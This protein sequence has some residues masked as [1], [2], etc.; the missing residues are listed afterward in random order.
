MVLAVAGPALAQNLGNTREPYFKDTPI[1]LYTAPEECR[2]GGDTFAEAFVIE[3]LPFTDTGTTV[4]YVNDYDE[5]CPYQGSTSPDVVYRFTPDQ[6]MVIDVDLCGS[7]YDTKTYIYDETFFR[8][9]CN[10]DFYFNEVCGM[11]VSKIEYAQLLYGHSYYFVVDGYGGDA[12][13]Y[14][15]NIT[16][17][18]NCVIECPTD[19]VDEGEPALH[20]GYVDMHNGGCNSWDYGSPFQEIN[21]T[22]DEDGD[23]PYDG[24]AWLCGTSGWYLVSNNSFRDTDWFRVYALHDGV[25]DFTVLTEYPCF[26]FKLAPTDCEGVAVELQAISDCWVPQT[27]SFPVT[28]GEEIWLWVGPTEFDGPVTEFLYFMTVTNNQFDV[29][30]DEDMSWGGVKALYR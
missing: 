12:G 14:L 28:A 6:D 26:M 23:P 13:E 4:G 11:Y 7:V 8:I 30:P 16:D 19:A 27:L 25:M 2:Q 9:A 3:S 10:D 29:V 15:L 24:E 18:G 1:K 22:N 5:P 21:W 20:D 17:P